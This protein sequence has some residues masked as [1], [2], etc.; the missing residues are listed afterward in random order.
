MWRSA[1][2]EVW[3]HQHMEMHPGP[4]EV[5]VHQ[6]VKIHPGPSEAWVHQP[7]GPLG[8]TLILTPTRQNF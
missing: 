6:H 7:F 3:V 4:P 8:V 2:P 5:W 1:P